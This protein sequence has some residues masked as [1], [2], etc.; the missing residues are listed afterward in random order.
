MVT[1]RESFSTTAQSKAFSLAE[2]N[3]NRA[4]WSARLTLR[5]ISL[6]PLTTLLQSQPGFGA[7]N[8]LVIVLCLACLLLSAC[9][10]S[11]RS[12]YWV[13][14]SLTGLSTLLGVGMV[15]SSFVNVNLVVYLL[16]WVL[17]LSLFANDIDVIY[18]IL[19]EDFKWFRLIACIWCALVLIS[20]PLSSSYYT[21]FN[22]PGARYFGSFTGDS[23]RLCPT[24]LEVLVFLTL[25]I[26][27]D[28][29]HRWL[30]L[31]LSLLPLYSAFMGYSRTYLGVILLM[32]I[33][34]LRE[35]SSTK[36]KFYLMLAVG[37]LLA[38]LFIATSSIGSKFTATSQ[39]GYLGFW[40][41][42]TS[43]RSSFWAHDIRSF[44]RFD[45]FHQI[46][47]GGFNKIY[48]INRQ[49]G[50]NI[51]AHN[52]FINLAVTNGYLG[53]ILYFAP[54]VLLI[55]SSSL[56]RARS[57]VTG[58]SGIL[59]LQWLINAVFNMEYTYV[60][61]AAAMA[62]SFIIMAVP[63]SRDAVEA[64]PEPTVKRGI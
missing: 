31:F 36:S 60:C 20:I 2:F 37:A 35:F 53:L 47:G 56:L 15:T 57:K 29:K 13:L 41:T 55:R 28:Y 27:R 9:L 19:K 46:F 26:K 38:V 22:A 14:F 5:S 39:A 23:F 61:A 7:I 12:V 54:L 18:R 8:Q 50:V 30:Y 34:F 33:P 64:L 21:V 32:Y 45:L 49:I 11:Y 4:Y 59:L 42:L 58:Y 25:C 43:G 1:V 6:L 17:L 16:F 40:D 51:W 63:S 44:F 10:M 52:D 24:A 3:S 62:F 48:E